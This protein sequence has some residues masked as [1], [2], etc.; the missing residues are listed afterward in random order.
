MSDTKLREQEE[1]GELQ[2]KEGKLT[3]TGQGLPCWYINRTLSADERESI[4]RKLEELCGMKG[5][6]ED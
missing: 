2:F 5:G 4:T 6:N 1:S 3:F